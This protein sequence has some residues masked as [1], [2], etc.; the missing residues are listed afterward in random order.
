MVQQHLLRKTVI[1]GKEVD[2]FYVETQLTHYHSVH[3]QINK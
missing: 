1:A 2:D 3:K